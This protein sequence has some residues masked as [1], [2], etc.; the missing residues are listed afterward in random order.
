MKVLLAFC[1]AL[2]GLVLPV[3]AHAQSKSGR[4]AEQRTDT[5]TV[6]GMPMASASQA[7][8]GTPSALGTLATLGSDYKIGPNDLMDIEV[9]GVPDLKRTVRVNAGGQV[10]LALIGNITISGMTAQEAEVKIA[11]K[12]AEKYLQNPEVSL[13]IKEYTTQRITVEGAVTKPGIYPVTGNVTL[14][15]VLALAGGGANYADM[16]EVMVF[17]KSPR[18][19]MGRENYDVERIRSGELPDPVVMAEDVVVVKRSGARTFFRDSLFRD[20]ID[21]M[22]PFSVL[23][24]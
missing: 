4:A 13:F 20:V 24:Q 21:A 6:P 11:A 14:L 8:S 17:R 12:Y 16:N 15:R 10:S 23:S 2:S 1:L 19:E 7:M 3:T 9:F 18:G 22:N 5:T